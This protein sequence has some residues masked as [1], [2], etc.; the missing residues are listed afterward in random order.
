MEMY[1]WLSIHLTLC[2]MNIIS[3][4]KFSITLLHPRYWGVWLGFALL[5]LVVNIFPYFLLRLIGNSIG[6]VA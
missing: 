2:L 3:S 1:R 4:P 6:L 5:A